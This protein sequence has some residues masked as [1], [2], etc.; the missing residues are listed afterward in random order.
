MKAMKKKALRTAI[1]V[2]LVL[3]CMATYAETDDEIIELILPILS[4]HLSGVAGAVSQPY[5]KQSM[6]PV[7][8]PG[9]YP[10]GDCMSAEP[11]CVIE[12]RPSKLMPVRPR[13]PTTRPQP[14]TV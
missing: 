2:S 3:S 11:G 12:A 6:I 10:Q 13:D 9:G 5:T 14:A 7:T 4:A 8:P 1:A